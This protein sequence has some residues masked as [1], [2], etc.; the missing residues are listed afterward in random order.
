MF[1]FIFGYS[2]TFPIAEIA[3]RK[4]FVYRGFEF[5]KGNASRYLVMKKMVVLVYYTTRYMH[6]H[7]IIDCSGTCLVYGESLLF[8]GSVGVFVFWLSV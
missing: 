6:V 7:I 3:C 8:A 5:K 2:I 1:R 4:E